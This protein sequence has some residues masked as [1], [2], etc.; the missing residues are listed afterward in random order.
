MAITD[1]LKQLYKAEEFLVEG[2]WDDERRLNMVP[3]GKSGLREN[4]LLSKGVVPLPDDRDKILHKWLN[5]HARLGLLAPW[6]AE[7]WKDN[8]WAM[9]QICGRDG[10]LSVV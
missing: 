6:V 1:D 10:R 9:A 5:D 3:G 2:H 8:D 7:K 4:G